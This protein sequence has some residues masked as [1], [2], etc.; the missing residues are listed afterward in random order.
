M[1][2]SGF[3]VRVLWLVRVCT[4]WLLCYSFSSVSCPVRVKSVENLWRSVC[5]SRWESCGKVSTECV[6]RRFST[7]NF[8]KVAVLH[9]AVDKFCFGFPLRFFPVRRGFSTFSTRS[10]TTTIN[11]YGLWRAD[12]RND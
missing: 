7:R 10:T 5:E 3:C 2:S 9:S 6:C 11:L 12:L 4:K 1:T 8:G